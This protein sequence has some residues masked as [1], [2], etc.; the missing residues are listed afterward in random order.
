MCVPNTACI[1]KKNVSYASSP[2]S[3]IA[4]NIALQVIYHV[5]NAHR[6]ISSLVYRFLRLVLSNRRKKEKREEEK[7]AKIGIMHS[8]YEIGEIMCK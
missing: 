6:T 7:A 4:S 5:I 1:R 3:V 2:C 8:L